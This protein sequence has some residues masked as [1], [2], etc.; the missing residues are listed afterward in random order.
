MQPAVLLS[1][2][3]LF[4]SVCFEVQEWLLSSS[5]VS[6]VF[7]LFLFLVI[8]CTCIFCSSY[9]ILKPSI[10]FQLNLS[11]FSSNQ[12]KYQFVWTICYRKV[13]ALI[14][15]IFF[16]NFT[17]L[18][19]LTGNTMACIPN[20]LPVQTLTQYFRNWLS[21]YNH[22][23]VT[24]ACLNNS[25]W[26]RQLHWKKKSHHSRSSKR[27]FCSQSRTRHLTILKESKN[28]AL[29]IKHVPSRFPFQSRKPILSK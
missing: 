23:K 24:C 27:C 22:C 5:L 14:A 26:R 7:F 11:P 8:K 29:K 16:K 9:W 20:V 18:Q 3:L 6:P 25:I 4:G 21:N 15:Q 12:C 19:V 1:I 13:M 2:L 10:I 28:T 17:V